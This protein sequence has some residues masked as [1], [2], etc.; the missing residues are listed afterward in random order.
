LTREGKGK[1]ARE[2][3]QQTG[4]KEIQTKRSLQEPAGTVLDWRF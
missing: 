2:A 1:V 4:K 3:K